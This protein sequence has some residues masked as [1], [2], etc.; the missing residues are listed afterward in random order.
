[1]QWAFDLW[2][3]AD[4]AKHAEPILARIK[5]GEMPCDGVWP[6][7]WVDAFTRWIDQGKAD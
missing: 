4:V 6:S 1:M 7:E 2:D 3:H 5:A